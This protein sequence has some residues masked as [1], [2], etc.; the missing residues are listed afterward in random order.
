MSKNLKHKF[1]TYIFM[2]YALTKLFHKKSTCHVACVKK[3][4][5]NKDLSEDKFSFFRFDYKKYHFF[6]KLDEYTYIMK[7]YM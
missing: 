6:V 5:L 3:T 2:C 1:C 4:K 7:M